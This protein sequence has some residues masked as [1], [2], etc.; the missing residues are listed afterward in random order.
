MWNTFFGSEVIYSRKVYLKTLAENKNK[1]QQ[2]IAVDTT[3]INMKN[4]LKLKSAC[5]STIF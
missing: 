5:L 4:V 1:T 3:K 2:P